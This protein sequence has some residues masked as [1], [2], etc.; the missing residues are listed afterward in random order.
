MKNSGKKNQ[1]MDIHF[2]PYY[3]NLTNNSISFNNLELVSINKFSDN[4]SIQLNQTN[5]FK[6]IL[7]YII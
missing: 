3:L 1:E 7:Y 6:N 4:S 5:K 2:V